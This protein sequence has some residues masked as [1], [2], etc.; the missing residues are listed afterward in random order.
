M[1][2][3][4]I[5]AGQER[6]LLWDTNNVHPESLLRV[7]LV[8]EALCDTGFSLI[9]RAVDASW[10]YEKIVPISLGGFNPSRL[11]YFYGHGSP[12]GGWL[13][14]PEQSARGF[15][16]SDLLTRD[17]LFMAHDY[18]HAWAYAAINAL[19]PELHLFDGQIS[20]TNF[21]DFVFAHI[22]T[23]AV[24]TVGL[25]YWLLSKAD[26]NSFCDIGSTISPLTISYRE[27]LLPEYRR[28][29]PSLDVQTPEFLTE[30]QDFYCTG[31]F[32]G[33]TAD[34]LKRSPQLL[35]WLKHELD[36]GASQRVLTR[37]WFA[38]LS[39]ETITL[40]VEESA[41]PVDTSQEA[42]R[43]VVH[44]LQYPLWEKI[45]SRNSKYRWIGSLIGPTPPARQSRDDRRPP[46]FRFANIN[47]LSSAEIEQGL[48]EHAPASTPYLCYQ[49]VGRTER[50]SVPDKLVKH[51]PQLIATRNL[52]LLVDL[53]AGFS[54]LI[55]NEGEPR[56]LFIV[57]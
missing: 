26:V 8:K 23:E 39:E 32:R 4:N 1:S 9:E 18:L 28:F 48:E 38:H 12:F 37:A 54:T 44:E 41:G 47:R 16:D 40:D 5:P 43:F 51:I 33:F 55:P 15:N 29:N 14:S 50:S 22:L 10:T 25:D 56:D 53:L 36:Y 52:N 57:N 49:I 20:A 46:D 13:E 7:P 19:W 35:T 17:V 30:L 31:I 24:A 2:I 42:R 11:A 45:N 3:H 6:S 34:D 27:E 21:E